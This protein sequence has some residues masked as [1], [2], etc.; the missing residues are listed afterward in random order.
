MNP[1]ATPIQWLLSMFENLILAC[2]ET[3][4]LL[5]FLNHPVCNLT[6]IPFLSASGYVFLVIIPALKQ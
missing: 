3:L 5:S 4:L 1:G 2:A 6:T